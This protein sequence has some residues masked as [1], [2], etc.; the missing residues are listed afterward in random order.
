MHHFNG[1]AGKAEGHR[2][3]R[4]GSGPVDKLIDSGD[5]EAANGGDVG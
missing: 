5:F 1:A 3:Q 2:P 4:S